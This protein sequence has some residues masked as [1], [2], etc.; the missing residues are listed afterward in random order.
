VRRN[1]DKGLVEIK[2]NTITHLL[3]VILLNT[4]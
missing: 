1:Y 2:K 4:N 3:F